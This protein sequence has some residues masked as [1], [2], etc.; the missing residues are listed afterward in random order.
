MRVFDFAINV[1]LNHK[2][3]SLLLPQ[4]RAAVK[5]QYFSLKVITFEILEKSVK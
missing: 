3:S 5:Y 4:N 2:I 1:D